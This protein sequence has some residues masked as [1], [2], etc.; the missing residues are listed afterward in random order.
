MNKLIPSLI[1]GL[2]LTGCASTGDKASTAGKTQDTST[3]A[4][5]KI[6][7]SAGMGTP[8]GLDA[9][10]SPPIIP[11]I[12]YA[13]DDSELNKENEE[14][15]KSV[16]HYLQQHPEFKIEVSGNCDERGSAEYNVALG[17]RRARRV[18]KSLVDSGAEARQVQ[19]ISFGEEKPR[20]TCHDESCW[21]ENRR[22]D[23]VISAPSE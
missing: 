20:L 4:T 1:L 5:G 14:M 15:L 18:K 9:E 12:Y 3:I 13:F 23:L 22:T 6:Q 7:K 21:K 2:V 16:G 17:E 10:H 8:A 19:A 11:S